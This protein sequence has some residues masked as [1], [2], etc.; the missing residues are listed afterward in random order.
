MPEL[1]ASKLLPPHIGTKVIDRPRLL[2]LIAKAEHWQIAVITAPAGYGKTTLMVQLTGIIQKPLV[3][4]Q[5]DEY[6]N[7]P[8][9]FLHYFV[10]GVQKYFPGFGREVLRVVAQGGIEAH[11][12]LLV[13]AVVQELTEQAGGG[14]IIVL[15][16]YHLLSEPII[17]SFV[18]EL[19][20]Q[21]PKGIHLVIASRSALPL[22]LSRISLR[23]E[24][25]AIG[26]EELKYTRQEIGIFLGCEELPETLLAALEQKTA[27]WPAAL[28]FLENSSSGIQGFL[29]NNKTQ[30]IYD[31][32]A[33]EVLDRQSEQI[34]EFLLKTSV[35]DV[36]APA[37]CDL[38]LDRNDSYR[39]LDFLAQQQLLLTP[40]A[41][42]EKVYRYHHLF[43][44]FLQNRLGSNRQSLLR[45]AAMLA[46]DGGETKNA[47]EYLITARLYEDAI[48]IIKEVGQRMLNDGGWQTVARW[49][50][51]FSVE[52]IAGDAW[53]SLYRASVEVRRGRLAEAE[54]WANRAAALFASGENQA[55]LTESRLLAAQI[56]RRRGHYIESLEILEQV[57]LQS[58]V[59]PVEQPLAIPLEKALCLLLAGRFNE[60]KMT[61]LDAIEIVKWNNDSYIMA[62]LLEGLGDILCLQGDYHKALQT[63]Q[64]AAECSP[65]RI[66]PSYYMQD[67]IS[68]IYQDWGEFDKAFD[69]AKRHVAIKEKFGLSEALPSSHIQ[70]ASI[71]VDRGE[72]KLAEEH[73]NRAI[74]LI[75]D[76]NGEQFYLALNLIFLAQCLNLEG[77]WLEARAKAEEA[78]VVAK[79]QS[80]LA[81]AVCRSM[82]S[83]IFARTGSL[84]EG[85]EMLRMAVIDLERMEFKKAISHAYAFQAWFCFTTG[86]EVAMQQHARESL[87]LAAE[88]NYIQI[89]LTY[90]M[91]FQPILKIGLESGIEVTFVQRILVRQGEEAVPLLLE[92]VAHVES[93]VRLRTIVPLA[94]IGGSKAH[95]GI[96][97]LTTDS[98]CEVRQMARLTANRLGLPVSGGHEIEVAVP[99]LYIATLGP[100]RAIIHG[101]ETTWRTVKTR[102]LLAYL[103]HRS[104]P[105]S[106]EKILEDLWPDW[107]IESAAVIFHTTLYNLRKYLNKVGDQEN[108]LYGGRRY[109]L[110]SGSFT[111]D[112]QKFQ[113]LVAAGL[114]AEV[115]PELATMQLEQAVA[116]YRGDYLE[117]MDYAWLFPQQEN[118]KHLCIEARIR[119]ARH[120][121]KTQDYTRAVCHL[122]IVEEYDPF[123]EEV[124][125]LLMKIFAKQGNRVA[126]KK[127]YQRLQEVLKRELGLVPSPE[128]NRLYCN[129]I[130]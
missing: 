76:N 55:G 114:R 53:L 49:L 13:V 86:E 79:Q 30:G 17:H 10:A 112:R 31:Y 52:C 78:L 58:T 62:H 88:L 109:Q 6:D 101:G 19:M 39:I 69:Y 61:L 90:R 108:I 103:A 71:H 36:M 28:R 96:L 94:E 124:Y 85:K 7:D 120:A 1:I 50:E 100:F 110:R 80:G 129:L 64:K 97:S 68:T 3:W 4:Y 38:L 118:L 128:I 74:Q 59:P 92:L 83:V 70:L 84:R 45:R 21:L 95:E 16:D 24:V 32:L 57:S 98:D 15:D 82:G 123:A 75:R 47:V 113:E 46:R 42:Q 41:G 26:M 20:H 40:L 35:L 27:G 107:D 105:V 111:S 51:P 87:K 23:G 29:S 63:Y 12:R 77:R 126:I 11:L 60:A 66:L 106:K 125:I 65:E 2:E 37:F 115:A 91:L 81:L 48:T 104:E 56:L 67:A 33:A 44:E 8:A 117:E 34:K 119:L 14:M 18:Q 89:F 73:Y 25:C 9:I 43:R 102:D 72:W 130:G 127:Q 93:E 5:L 121:L 116:L 22:S 122:Q 54:N 99:L